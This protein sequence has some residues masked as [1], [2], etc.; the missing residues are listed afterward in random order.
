MCVEK[1]YSSSHNHL[2]PISRRVLRPTSLLFLA[3]NNSNNSSQR[4]RHHDN[5]APISRAPLRLEV[6]A[7]AVHTPIL[8]LRRILVKHNEI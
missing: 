1:S 3:S 2:L 7:A 4:D 5:L 8:P 6:Q